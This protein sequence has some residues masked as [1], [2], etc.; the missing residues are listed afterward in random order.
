MA[1]FQKLVHGEPDWDSK[2]NNNFEVL[3]SQ[4]QDN[5]AIYKGMEYLDSLTQLNGAKII[6][7]NQWIRK[8]KF[9]DFD[10]I[11]YNIVV[12]N[13]TAKQYQNTTLAAIPS[14][15]FD[16]YSKLEKYG[17]VQWSDN[18]VSYDSGFDLNGNFYVW[19]RSGSLTNEECGFVG[20]EIATKA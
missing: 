9:K 8:M 12:S 20:I 5:S 4:T 14:S 7:G 1:D 15:F 10:L 2:I 3:N 17:T 13:I 6:N 19:P 11:M 18:N 16:G